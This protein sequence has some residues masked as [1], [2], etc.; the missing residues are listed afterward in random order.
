MMAWAT[1]IIQG[2]SLE[3][4]TAARIVR[5][6]DAVGEPT[7]VSRTGGRDAIDSR[8]LLDLELLIEMRAGEEES[9]GVEGGPARKDAA[10]V[11]VE[12]VEDNDRAAEGLVCAIYSAEDG[13]AACCGF[14]P[15]ETAR[16]CWLPEE[17]IS[18]ETTAF[19]CRLLK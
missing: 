4:L 14:G 5:G 11:G 17:P 16:L 1:A 10:R 19:D 18:W 7:I 3:V 9:G 13:V 6:G 15:W 12:V 2:A 8:R